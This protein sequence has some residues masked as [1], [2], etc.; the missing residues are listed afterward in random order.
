MEN[1]NENEMAESLCAFVKKVRKIEEFDPD[2]EEYK[3]ETLVEA[4]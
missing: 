4:N 1:N 2:E 3:I